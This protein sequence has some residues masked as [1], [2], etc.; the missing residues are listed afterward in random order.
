MHDRAA[1]VVAWLEALAAQALDDEAALAAAGGG[2][3]G[4]FGAREGVWAETRLRLAA[5]VARAGDQPLV[6]PS[7]NPTAT[8]RKATGTPFAAGL[9]QAAHLDN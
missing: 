9:M 7:L 3:A 8:L 1:R 5:G 2:T 4:R 6:R